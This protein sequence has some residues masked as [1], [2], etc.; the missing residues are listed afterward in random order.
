MVQGDRVELGVH[1]T[2]GDQ[3]GQRRREPQRARAVAVVDVAP[4][5]RLDA[6]PVAGQH[7]AAGVGLGHREGEHALEVVDHA[8]APLAVA[9]EDHLG[10]AVREEPVALAEQLRRSSG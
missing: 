9:L 2:C 1:P 5:Q 10:V 4:V 6:E 3:R 8:L 7:D